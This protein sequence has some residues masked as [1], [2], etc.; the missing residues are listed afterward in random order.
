MNRQRA[1]YQVMI[2]RAED[3]PRT[4]L[5]IIASVRKAIGGKPVAFVDAMVKV[6]FAGHT[7]RSKFKKQIPDICYSFATSTIQISFSKNKY[8]KF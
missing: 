7:V 8:A 6:S 2:V 5:G 3:L 1:S 4:D